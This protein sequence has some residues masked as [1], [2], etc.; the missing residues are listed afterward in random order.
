MAQCVGSAKCR[1]RVAAH[2]RAAREPFIPGM[3]R[4]PL[5]GA[6]GAERKRTGGVP[7]QLLFAACQGIT[8]G[9]FAMAA[10]SSDYKSM[11]NASCGPETADNKT[12]DEKTR[13]W[14]TCSCHAT[15]QIQCIADDDEDIYR[16]MS[17]VRCKCDRCGPCSASGRRQCTIRVLEGLS[18]FCDRCRGNK[19]ILEMIADMKNEELFEKSCPGP[20]RELP[21]T[22]SEAR[23][24]SELGDILLEVLCLHGCQQAVAEFL[25]LSDLAATCG[26][27]VLTWDSLASVRDTRLQQIRVCSCGCGLRLR[28]P[29]SDWLRYR[30]P[31]DPHRRLGGYGQADVL[32]SGS[33][34]ISCVWGGT[35][36]CGVWGGTGSCASSAML[37]QWECWHSFSQTSG[38]RRSIGRKLWHCPSCA[39]MQLQWQQ[40]DPEFGS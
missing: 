37:Y 2:E 17:F 6:R 3:S 33:L 10:T 22:D 5:L 26:L 25:S 40:Q 24:L 35:G 39:K 23:S 27:C 8:P 18:V 14:C 16:V 11:D 15:K 13:P 9:H 1:L 30:C 36:S 38:W 7:E 12:N 20:S 31:P 28:N 29:S 21:E 34:R 32:P 19:T 4:G